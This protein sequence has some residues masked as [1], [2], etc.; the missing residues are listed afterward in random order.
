M[1]SGFRFFV[2]DGDYLECAQNFATALGS[3]APE[4]VAV[5]SVKKDAG[6]VAVDAVVKDSK[7]REIR[8]EPA[9]RRV[10]WFVWQRGAWRLNSIGERVGLGPPCHTYAGHPC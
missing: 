7:G 10:Y 5:T 3:V 8:L 2:G 1:S 4:S 9:G 6:Q